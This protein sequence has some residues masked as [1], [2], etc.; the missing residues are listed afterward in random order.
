MIIHHIKKC[1]QTGQKG[2]KGKHAEVVDQETKDLPTE[3]QDTENE[4]PDY[5]V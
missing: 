3:N 5:E 1:K 4:G 2:A